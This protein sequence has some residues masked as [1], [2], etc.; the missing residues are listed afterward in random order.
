[1]FSAAAARCLAIVVAAVFMANDY[2]RVLIF[3]SSNC[4]HLSLLWPTFWVRYLFDDNVKLK[5]IFVYINNGSPEKIQVVLLL[6]KKWVTLVTQIL[7]PYGFHN[8]K[9]NSV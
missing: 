7:T 1:M 5:V 8:F 3:Q 9:N 6:H 2:D 4:D